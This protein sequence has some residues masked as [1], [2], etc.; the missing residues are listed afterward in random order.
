MSGQ[1][2]T[3]RQKMIGM[4]YLVLTALLALNIS[5]DILDAFVIVNESLAATSE[6]TNKK[7]NALYSDFELARSID[8]QKVDNYWARSQE[9]RRRATEINTFIDSIKTTLISK[10]E[11][12]ERSVAD[13]L[14][15]SLI[16]KKDDYDTPTNILIGKKEDGSGGLANIL[17]N[18]ILEYQIAMR[19]LLNKQ[20]RTHFNDRINLED[21]KLADQTSTWETNNFYHTPLVASLVI[22]S[23][24]QMDVADVEYDVV[25]KLYRS[26]NQKDF[27]FDT[28]AATVLPQ[29]NYVLLGEDYTSD[30]IVAAYSTTRSPRIRVGKLNEAGTELVLQEDTVATENGKGLFRRKTTAEGIFSYAGMVDLIDSEGE[31]QSYPFRSEYIVARPSLVVSPTQMNVFY[32]G[33]DNPVSISVPGVPSERISASITGGNSLRKVGSSSYMAIMSPSSP[34]TVYVNVSATMADGTVRNMG[35]ME[36]R[37]KRLPT[38]FSAINRK[39][40]SVRMK[41]NIFK[42]QIGLS[43]K[44]A[45]DFAFQLSPRVRKFRVFMTDRQGQVILNEEFNGARFDPTLKDKFSK[46]KRGYKII[47]EN[48]QSKGDDEVE[49]TLSPIIITIS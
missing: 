14:S 43:A 8:P 49:H 31:T 6:T 18:K 22:L 16:A 10:T 35:R 23:K 44:Y 12:V 13:T 7:M 28:I 46:V 47:F 36:F 40:G 15:M 4:M 33:I 34:S 20:D 9:A 30:I 37:A 39:Q 32:K 3:S 26:F 38:P 27:F 17:K 42:A 24:L 25:N 41:P 19:Q 48:I 5:K 2:E 21:R 11:K 1:K 45:D 29:S